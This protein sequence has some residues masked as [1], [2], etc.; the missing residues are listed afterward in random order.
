MSLALA[1][2]RK[3]EYRTWPNPW[4]GTLIVKAG[5]VISR[6]WHRGPGLP[7]AE[8]D[9]LRRAGKRAKGS[10]LY[11]TLEPCQHYGKTPPCTQAIVEAGVKRVV[12]ACPD[13]NAK[14]KGGL[15]KL[16]RAGV[17]VGPW[18]LRDEAEALNRHFLFSASMGRPWVTLKAGI[19]LDGRT[20]TSK[21]ESKWITSDEA[22]RDSR[23][24]RGQCGA[25][26]VGAGTV[27]S[28]DPTLLPDDVEGEPPWR[29]VLDPKGRLSG[30]EKI[31]NDAYSAH[32]VWFTGARGVVAALEQARRKGVHVQPDHAGGLAGA[33][34]SAIEWL[35]E[36][37]IRRLLVEGG[38]QT[39]GA[40]LSA[41]L[42]EELVLYYASKVSGSAAS[43]GLFQGEE[44]PLAGWPRL[45]I[46]GVQRVGPDLR[47]DAVFQKA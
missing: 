7:H 45:R 23:R 35:A 13:P 29:L 30:R 42:A 26:L 37:E 43:L 19:S 27:A 9:A 38:P 47:V 11:V 16:K 10:T 15:A 8:V 1:E 6:G 12:A 21:R 2:A 34:R 14:A 36:R 28:D 40:F 25:V 39:L 31:F 18:V 22:R 20:A 46:D 4:V 33:V 17:S 5:R 44:R 24:L 32:S 41:G 3:G